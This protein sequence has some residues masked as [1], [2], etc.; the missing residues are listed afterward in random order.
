MGAFGGRTRAMAFAAARVTTGLMVMVVMVAC[1]VGR[2]A[3]GAFC[4]SSAAHVT[5]LASARTRT[6]AC[7]LHVLG[8]RGSSRSGISSSSSMYRLAGHGRRK[9]GWYACARVRGPPAGMRRPLS[10]DSWRQTAGMMLS[11]G[12]SCWS[13]AVRK[14]NGAKRYR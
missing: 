1:A 5:V 4:T 3:P 14:R 12:R 2:P 13:A 9:D 7:V 8:R 11:S 10:A 6:C